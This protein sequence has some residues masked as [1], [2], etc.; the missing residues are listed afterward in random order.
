MEEEND[1][2]SKAMYITYVGSLVNIIL[3]IAKLIAG[4]FGNSAALVADAMHSLSDLVTDAIVLIGLKI[5]KRPQDDTHNYGHGKVETLV[6]VIIGIIL[7]FVGIG[8]FVGGLKTVLH[9]FHGGTIA[10][11]SI[12]AFIVAASSIV[13][14][15][16]LYRYTVDAGKK[17]KSNILIANAWHHRSDSLSSMGVLAGIGGS[18]VLGEQWRILDP[19]AA[20]LVSLF[21]IN[22]AVKITKNSINDLIDCSIGEE[23]KQEIINALENTKGIKSI[24]DLRTRRIGNTVAIEVHICIDKELSLIKA[25]NI[26]SNA[27]KTLKEICG[28]DSIIT[29]HID[30]V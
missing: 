2:S 21:I 26:S 4:I 27:E 24:H 12:A 13:L 16:W 18:I 5:S 17:M 29:I 3:T 22:V 25:H 1:Y 20:M 19:I 30:P 23:K 10:R 9:V 6:S 8:I 7:L 14:K 11:P 15:E 28:I